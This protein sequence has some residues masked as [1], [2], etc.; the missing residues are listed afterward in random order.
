MR[1]GAQQRQASAAAQKEAAAKTAAQQQKEEDQASWNTP[2]AWI[3][4]REPFLLAWTPAI[5][6]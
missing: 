5:I 1:G 4:S 6:Q 2:K 3:C